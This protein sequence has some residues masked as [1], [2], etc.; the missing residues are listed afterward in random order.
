MEPFKALS[1]YFCSMRFK[2]P[3]PIKP[4]KVNQEW[5]IYA[6]QVYS[7][8]GFSRHNGT[9]VA[10]GLDSLIRAPFAGTVVRAGTKE[11]GGWQPNG[12]GVFCG[13][14]SDETFAFDD[15]KETKVLADFLHCD[16]LVVTESQHVIAGQPLAV[17][18]NTGFSTG[19]HTHIQLRRVL[20]QK[21]GIMTID[22]NEANNSF[23]PKPYYTNTY[24]ID[25]EL[26]RIQKAID[27]IA[28][29]LKGRK[30]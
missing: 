23:D 15:G 5:G 12:G 17:A 10:L 28:D 25:D 30:K 11:N 18:D 21:E 19:P 3:Y 8:F 16:H 24:T 4:Y 14:V 6:P 20:W 27:S 7:Q 13:L 22:Q 26:S 9:D 29:W 1:P 2:F